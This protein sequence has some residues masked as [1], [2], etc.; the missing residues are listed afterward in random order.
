[1][2][3]ALY[4]NFCAFV[5]LIKRLAA[6]WPSS[7]PRF[8]VRVSARSGTRSYRSCGLDLLFRGRQHG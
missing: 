8:A 7:R 4:L 5:L 3:K 2:R 1:L 6:S